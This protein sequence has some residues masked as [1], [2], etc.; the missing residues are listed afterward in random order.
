MRD[1]PVTKIVRAY[2]V[3]VGSLL[4]SIHFG[5][6]IHPFGMETQAEGLAVNRFAHAQSTYRNSF[7][8]RSCWQRLVKASRS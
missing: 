4:L 3:W 5:F 8:L 2:Y 1:T 7:E 6:E